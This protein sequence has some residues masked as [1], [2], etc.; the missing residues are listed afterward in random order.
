MSWEGWLAILSGGIVGAT[1]G[2]TGAGGSLLSIPLLVYGLGLRVQEA[3]AT[4][5]LVVAGSAGLGA[6]AHLRAGDVRLR[7]AA[8]FTASGWIGAWVGA[9]GHRVVREE[10]IL[11]LFGV[12]M[13]AV[14]W[15]MRQGHAVS[16]TG[17]GSPRCAEEMPRLCVIRALLV[18]FLVGVMT[19]FFGVGG[20]FII[21]PA[22]SMILGFPM[23]VAVG[24]SLLIMTLVSLGGL[25]G[26]LQHGRIN[27]PVTGLLLVGGGLGTLVGTELARRATPGY[28]NKQF[29]VLAAGIAVALI[30]HNGIMLIGR[31]L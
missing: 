25:V 10:L 11:V 18:G 7:A 1:L 24:T 28:L 21:V 29:A 4:S 5:L 19:G 8:L 17:A 15:R 27:W 12:L 31:M 22:L 9:F 23:Q 13:L 3:T 16:F 20:G 26:H 2:A 14:A 6:Y 30:F